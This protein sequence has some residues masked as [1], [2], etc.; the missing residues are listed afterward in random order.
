M[1]RWFWM[2]ATMN[3]VKMP[4]RRFCSKCDLV[5]LDE[6][7]RNIC[8][9]CECR[10]WP[11]HENCIACGRLVPSYFV[12]RCAWCWEMTCDECVHE[13]HEAVCWGDDT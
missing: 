8:P 6:S 10:E 2:E 4:A 12:F 9:A 3:A 5:L 1:G 11:E 13:E 7:E